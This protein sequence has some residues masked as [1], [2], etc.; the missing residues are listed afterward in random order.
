VAGVHPGTE[1]HVGSG[2][3]DSDVVGEVVEVVTIDSEP[4]D[5]KKAIFR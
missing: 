1:K 5:E 2:E 3:A 4:D